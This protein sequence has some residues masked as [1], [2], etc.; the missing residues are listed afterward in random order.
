MA[1]ESRTVQNRSGTLENTFV[2]HGIHDGANVIAIERFIECLHHGEGRS[3]LGFQLLL[4]H[5]VTSPVAG[6]A[7]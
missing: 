4:S 7:T 3:C 5:F 6:P 2:G 1:L